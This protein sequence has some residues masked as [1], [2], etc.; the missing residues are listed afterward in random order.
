MELRDRGINISDDRLRKVLKSLE[1]DGKITV[2]KGRVGCM[3]IY[4]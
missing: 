2:G 4:T 1:N 3:A